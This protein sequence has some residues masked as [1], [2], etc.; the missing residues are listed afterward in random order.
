[1]YLNKPQKNAPLDRKFAKPKKEPILRQPQDINETPENMMINIKMT[2]LTQN[3]KQDQ[4]NQVIQKTKD[5]H[6][7]LLFVGCLVINFPLSLIIA[8]S[9]ALS[10]RTDIQDPTSVDLTVEIAKVDT[11]PPGCCKCPTSSTCVDGMADL[12]CPAS[13]D[14]AGELP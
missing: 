4:K 11:S 10:R 7:F 8:C 13:A 5:S 2:R 14:F 12:Q 3:K 1:M 6:L 9:I